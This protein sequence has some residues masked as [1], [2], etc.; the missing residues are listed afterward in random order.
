MRHLL[1]AL[2]LMFAPLAHA[3]VVLPH[4]L[5]DHA[6][7]QRGRPIHIWGTA[8]PG[9]HLTAHFHQQT[10]AAVADNI[11]SFSLYLAPETAGGPYLLTL[12]GDG[13]DKTLSDLLVGDVW[14]ASGQSNMEMPLNGFPPGAVIKDAA[15]EIA[16]ATN[17]RLRLLLVDRKGSPYPLGD[18]TGGSWT[19]CTPETAARFSAVAYFYGREIAAKENVPIGLI[20]SSWGGTPADSWVSLDTLGTDAQL[21][22]AFAARSNFARSYGS[23]E[24]IVAAEKRED[25]DAKAAGKPAPVHSWHPDPTSWDPAGLYNG[26]IAP[27]TPL[28]IKGFLWYQGETNSGPGRAQ[29]YRTLFPAL[30]NDWRSHF[31]QGDLPFL[32]V[33]ISSYNSPGEDWGLVRDAQRRTLSLAGTAMAVTLDIGLAGNVHPPDKQ[34]VAYR[35][36]LAARSMVYGEPIAYAPPL[37][38]QATTELMPDGTT[39]LRVYFDHGEHLTSNG[40]PLDQ[41][42]LAGEDH[43]FVKADAKL[44]GDTVLVSAPSLKHPMYVRYG[45]ASVVDTSLYNAAGLP[46]STFTSEPDPLK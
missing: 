23:L 5:G 33:Q 7:L 39:A 21:L 16:A 29:F 25:E 30:I 38:R 45:W 31:A 8:T 6:V 9:A 26:M 40:K 46:A 42:E 22:P 3:E 43:A 37:F 1:P 35:L 4:A 13:P 34:T 44:E 11:G 20:D 17:P 19:T 15:K 24:R 28:S 10:V 27:F 18:I 36:A 14:F 32:F 41:F 2:L 12:S